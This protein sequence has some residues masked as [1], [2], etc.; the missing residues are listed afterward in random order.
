MYVYL[1]LHCFIDALFYFFT[2]FLLRLFIA[3]QIEAFNFP[4]FIA[5]LS[6]C[7]TVSLLYCFTALLFY[8]LLNTTSILYCVTASLSM[9]TS[10]NCFIAAL[11]YCFTVLLHCSTL[12]CDTASLSNCFTAFKHNCFIASQIC[13]FFNNCLCF[14]T[15]LSHC[16]HVSLIDCFSTLPLYFLLSLLPSKLNCPA[17]ITSL[18]YCCISLPYCSV[19]LPYCTATLFPV[20][21][22]HFSLLYSQFSIASFFIVSLPHCPTA[23]LLQWFLLC[24]SIAWRFTASLYTFSLF[25]CCTV[26]LFYSLLKTASYFIVSLPHRSCSLYFTVALQYCFTALLLL[27]FT[28]V[29]RSCRF[30]AS[31]YTFPSPQHYW[32][33]ILL[34]LWV[35]SNCS[36]DLLPKRFTASPYSFLCFTYLTA[37]LHFCWT[38]AQH[39]LTF[40]SINASLPLPTSLHS[41][42]TSLI[43]WFTSLLLYSITASASGCSVV[44]LL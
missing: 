39:Y 14:T 22:L 7:F 21:V 23:S 44:S 10:L 20:K 42:T 4:C 28:A 27:C 9:L 35:T 1:L 3:S 30:N 37:L 43:H 17:H 26:F 6:H 12:P 41:F 16:F 36:T 18:L 8:F 2:A 13:S 24:C 29:L 31:L 5:Q 11:L 19:S 15:P 40:Y 33:Y 25:H 32:I 38:I 34:L